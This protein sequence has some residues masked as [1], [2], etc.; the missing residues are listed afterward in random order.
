MMLRNDKRLPDLGL[1]VQ[2]GYPRI[3]AIYQS[4][5][6]QSSKQA[7]ENQEEFISGYFNFCVQAFLDF[8]GFGFPRFW[9]SAVFDL[10]GF[11]IL[12]YFPPL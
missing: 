10:T 1:A 3:L 12:S 4:Y 7:L 8:H 6:H 5:D 9:I 11:I 2:P